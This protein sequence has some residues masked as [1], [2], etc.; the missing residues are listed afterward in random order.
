[1]LVVASDG[2][3]GLVTG[4]FPIG[5]DAFVNIFERV[6]VNEAKGRAEVLEYSYYLVVGGREV[7]GYDLDSSHD[8]AAHRHVE[9]HAREPWGKMSLREA[10]EEFWAIVSGR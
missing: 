5:N 8:P 10:V 7:R 3:A 4:R 9:N 6:V 1:M 2:A